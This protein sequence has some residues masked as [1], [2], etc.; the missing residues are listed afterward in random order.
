MYAT[1]V[2]LLHFFEPF[3]W[4]ETWR[5]WLERRSILKLIKWLLGQ[6]SPRS[7]LAKEGKKNH[8]ST[9]Y[10][11][12]T[13]IAVTECLRAR[14]FLCTK[15]VPISDLGSWVWVDRSHQHK[16]IYRTS[17]LVFFLFFLDRIYVVQ[18]SLNI[19]AQ[20]IFL[21]QLP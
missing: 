7:N 8:T 15:D 18:A 3:S 10:I 14:H 9:D 2:I 1:L 21:L 13:S 16:R 6:A 12:S 11:N 20:M 17:F 19:W 5:I 4:S